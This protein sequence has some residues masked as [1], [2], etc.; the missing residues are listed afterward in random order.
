MI[1]LNHSLPALIL[2]AALISPALSVPARADSADAIAGR[3]IATNDGGAIYR[4]L[5]QG[6]HMADG[7]GAAGAARFPALAGNPKLA[8]AGYPAYVVLNGFGGMPWFADKLSDTQVA[9]VVNY[10][11]SH[12]GNHYADTVG[13]ADIAPQRPAAEAIRPDID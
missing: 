4:T 5:C 7:R 6:C 13:P 10:V 3:A 2:L 9:A 11:R 12:F 1:R 8:A